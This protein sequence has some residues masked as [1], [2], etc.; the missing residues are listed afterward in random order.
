MYGEVYTWDPLKM[1]V[2][3][4]NCRPFKYAPMVRLW[5]QS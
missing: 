3:R 1:S 5:V 2:W 4:R